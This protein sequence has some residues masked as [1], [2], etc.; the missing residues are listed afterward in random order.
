MSSSG[1]RSGI[2]QVPES[3]WTTG[4]IRKIK[5]GIQEMHLSEDSDLDPYRSHSAFVAVKGRKRIFSSSFEE[6]GEG[7]SSKGRYRFRGAHRTSRTN[8][9][10]EGSSSEESMMRARDILDPKVD[11]PRP[12]KSTKPLPTDKERA[13]E[14]RRLSPDNLSRMI[15]DCSRVAEK[16]AAASSNLKGIHKRYL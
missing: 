11:P 3:V 10:S 16:V 1:D 15:A 5:E 12:S 13:I 6:S 14:L 8:L 2:A 4:T 7:F 9:G